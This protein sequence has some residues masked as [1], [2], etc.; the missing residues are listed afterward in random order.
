MASKI[1]WKFLIGI[2]HGAG[3][4]PGFDDW[5]F[6]EKRTVEAQLIFG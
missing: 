4:L 6:P 3:E 2:F 5:N 1:G